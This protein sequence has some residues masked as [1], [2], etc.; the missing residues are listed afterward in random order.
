M[1]AICNINAVS[2]YQIKKK[3]IILKK[4]Q[5]LFLSLSLFLSF[6]LSFFLSIHT[7][8]DFSF[9]NFWINGKNANR[10]SSIW[11]QYFITC[12]AAIDFDLY[13]FDAFLTEETLSLRNWTIVFRI[14]FVSVCCVCVCVCLILFY[15]W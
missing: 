1:F 12:V 13:G 11:S 3:K 6:F 2:I 7:S 14:L 4:K 8:V 5:S 15:C 10:L 9:K